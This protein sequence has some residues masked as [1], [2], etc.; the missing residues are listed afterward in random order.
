MGVSASK[1]VPSNFWLPE[2][3]IVDFLPLMRTHFGTQPGDGLAVQ[4][5]NT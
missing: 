4:L 5:A 3:K 1:P 2:L